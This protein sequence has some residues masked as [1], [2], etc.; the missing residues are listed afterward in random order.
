MKHPIYSA[1]AAMALATGAAL[2]IADEPTLLE[3]LKESA[4]KTADQIGTATSGAADAAGKAL[5]KAADSANQTLESTKYDLGDAATP[6][7]TRAKLDALAEQT[8]EQLFEK[9]PAAKRMFDE[10]AGYAVFV[11]RQVELLVAA[12]YGRG[13]AVD[14]E[15][16]QRTYMK[17]GSGGVGVGFGLGGFATKTVILFETPFAFNKFVTQGT[18]AS[19]EAGTMTGDQTDQLKFTFNDNGQAIFV[20]TGDG[21]KV[22]AKL[23]ATK[24]WPDQSL[25]T[26]APKD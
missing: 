15:T 1:V 5:D 17:M 24:Y 18:D 7:E 25:N 26:S 13:V 11:S 4:S 22:S 21:W 20:L 2:A 10:S 9:E 6:E 12:G 23:L 16:G 3:K 19:A 14:R 8:L